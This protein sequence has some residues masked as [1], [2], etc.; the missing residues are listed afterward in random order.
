VAARSIASSQR[1]VTRFAYLARRGHVQ[2]RLLGRDV[3][4]MTLVTAC[5]PGGIGVDRLPTC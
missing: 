4:I 1:L 5:A 3:C 2:V